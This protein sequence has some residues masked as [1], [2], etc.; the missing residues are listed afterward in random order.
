MFDVGCCGALFVVLTWCAPVGGVVLPP[1]PAPTFPPAAPAVPPPA[2]PQ[3]PPTPPTGGLFGGHDPL[4]RKLRVD[5]DRLRELADDER[6]DPAAE[7]LVVTGA[8]G[9]RLALDLGKRA[10]AAFEFDAV[11]G[12][13]FEFVARIDGGRA[14]AMM[15]LLDPHDVVREEIVVKPGRVTRLDTF[16]ATSTGTY[17]L[18]LAP[19]PGEE[20]GTL[21]VTT[22]A[23]AAADAVESVTLADGRPLPITLSGMT[24]RSLRS[25]VL[26]MPRGAT[27]PRPFVDLESP[28]G[29]IVRVAA[30]VVEGDPTQV[31]VDAVVLDE[32]GEW[33]LRLADLSREER[34]GTLTLAFEEPKPG[35]KLIRF[36]V[37]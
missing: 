24:G 35:R 18:A 10:A 13:R 20:R 36:E 6:N 16:T 31:V 9:D 19:Q 11:I 25:A 8:L 12:T 32:L 23:I 27:P 34:A 29:A 21:L 3:P 37:P 30:R 14:S 33:T 17:R 22:K 4:D 1:R 15:T 28:S 5:R 2:V 26:R 7:P